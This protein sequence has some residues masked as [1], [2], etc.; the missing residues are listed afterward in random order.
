MK[1]S[2]PSLGNVRFCPFFATDLS[3]IL[4]L[5]AVAFMYVMST[6]IHSAYGR[7]LSNIDSY[8]ATSL[9]L[10]LWNTS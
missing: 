9:T 4:Y 3:E 5:V 1:F 10:L 7:V 6:I 8:L 2:F